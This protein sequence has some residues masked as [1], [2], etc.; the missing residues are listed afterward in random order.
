MAQSIRE[1][2]AAREASIVKLQSEIADLN[3][4][5]ADEVDP[6]AAVVG[7]EVTFDYGKAPNRRTLTGIIIGRKDADPA[8]NKTYTQLK[9]A[10]GQGFDA[11]IVVIPV[12]S[13]TKVT[14]PAAA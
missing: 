11:E 5:L 3:T 6:A 12:A 13:V 1:K 2:I 14:A 4:Q 8:N 10:V 9:V 7:A